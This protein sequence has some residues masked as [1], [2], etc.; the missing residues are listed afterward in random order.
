MIGASPGGKFVYVQSSEDI[1]LIDMST[2]KI[3]LKHHVSNGE[4]AF[5]VPDHERQLLQVVTA[6]SLIVINTR[7]GRVLGEVE[8]ASRPQWLVSPE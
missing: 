8:G 5:I 2:N 1:T 6:R 3:H 7:E 4:I